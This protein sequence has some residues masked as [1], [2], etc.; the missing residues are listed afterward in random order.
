MNPPR[1]T[2]LPRWQELAVYL[3]LG[4][5]LVSGV[6]WLV[7]DQWVRLEGEFGPEH[8]PAQ[9]WLLIGHAVFAYGALIVAGAMIPVHIKLGWA[10]RRN[11][12]SGTVL[13]ATLTVLA[14]TALGLYYVGEEVAR[15]WTSV[16]HWIVGLLLLPAILVHAIRGRR[17][18]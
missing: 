2:R 13:A 8:H 10:I 7:L 6:A 9:H 5:L 14:V 17:G 4:A 18:A 1:P 15:H 11:R 3:T 16:V 12:E